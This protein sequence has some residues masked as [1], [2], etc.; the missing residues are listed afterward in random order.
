MAY[1]NY[2][3]AEPRLILLRN[4]RRQPD[5]SAIS[6]FWDILKKSAPNVHVCFKGFLLHEIRNKENQIRWHVPTILALWRQ[7]GG[8][9][10]PGQPEHGETVS[11]QKEM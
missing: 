9:Q 2:P 3:A 8:F 1:L 5:T 7:A 4:V 10:V 6:H 11:N